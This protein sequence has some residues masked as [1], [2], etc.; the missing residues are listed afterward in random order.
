MDGYFEPMRLPRKLRSRDPAVWVSYSAA[1]CFG[2]EL[3]KT[4]GVDQ[5]RPVA[6]TWLIHPVMRR[7]RNC[8]IA[9]S[10]SG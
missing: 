8:S 5:L 9:V 2:R 4:I 1:V 3:E 7:L 10:K 6:S